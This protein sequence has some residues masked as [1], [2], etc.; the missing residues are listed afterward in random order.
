VAQEFDLAASGTGQPTEKQIF[1]PLALDS[2]INLIK[3]ERVRGTVKLYDMT[4]TK[5]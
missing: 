4:V 3:I 5:F 2:R 1:I